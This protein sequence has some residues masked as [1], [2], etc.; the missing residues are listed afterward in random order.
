ME[1]LARTRPLFE[2]HFL[3]G[4][5]PDEFGPHALALVEKVHHALLDGISGVELM[6]VLFDVEAIDE[7]ERRTSPTWQVRRRHTRPPGRVRLA[8]DAIAESLREPT[9]LMRRAVDAVRSPVD[10]AAKIVTVVGALGDLVRPSSEIT[11]ELNRPVGSDRLL[12]PIVVPLEIVHDTGTALGGTVNDVVLTAIS[13]GVRA[14]L[15]ARGIPTA[16]PFT[17]LVPVSTRRRG[18]ETETG[19]HVSALVVELPIEVS[20]PDEAFGIVAERVSELKQHHHADGTEILL[21]AADHLPPVVVDLVSGLVGRQSLVNLV[22]TNLAGPPNMLY[23]RGGRV[24]EMI[25]IVPLGGNLPVGVAVLSYAGQLC[26]AF[27][28]DAEACP[29]VDVM[30]EATQKAFVDLARAAGVEP[31]PIDGLV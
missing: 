24:S 11:H 21:E 17:A 18:L 13:A 19:N 10:T 27:H 25:P 28:A 6:S 20:E 30:S 15:V 5:D 1:T 31:P 4:L 14:L 22:V 3:T 8:T 7:T 12:R 9:T 23:F 29:D 16:G 2:F 26:L